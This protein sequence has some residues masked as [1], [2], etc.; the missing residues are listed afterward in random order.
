MQ[1]EDTPI[2]MEYFN[3]MFPTHFDCYE[4]YFKENKVKSFSEFEEAIKKDVIQ[5]LIKD[6]HIGKRIEGV[7]LEP[8]T[9]VEIEAGD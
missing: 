6:G 5:E 7:C 9:I 3:R 1:I 8:D 2:F 4:R